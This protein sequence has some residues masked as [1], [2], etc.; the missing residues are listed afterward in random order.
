M[1]WMDGGGGEGREGV[2]GFMIMICMI[3]NLYKKEI[4]AFGFFCK[5][6]VYDNEKKILGGRKKRNHVLRDCWDIGVIKIKKNLIIIS[7]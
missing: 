3:H 2:R 7:V 4:L 1:R 6:F 5:N